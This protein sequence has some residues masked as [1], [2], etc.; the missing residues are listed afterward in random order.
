[1]SRGYYRTALW[2]SGVLDRLAP[3]D[4]HVAGTP[5]LGLDLPDSDIDILCHAPDLD[6]F[7][8]TVRAAFGEERGFVVKRWPDHAAV[9][10]RFVTLDWPIEIFGQ[11]LPVAEQQGWR[12]FE[13][14]RRLLHIGGHPLHDQVMA[15]R[16][17]G[18]KTEPA[19]ATLLK[20]EGDPHAAL[21][22][23]AD[24]PDARLAALLA[25][26]GFVVPRNDGE[27]PRIE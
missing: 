11:A 17:A 9:I 4:P 20:L 18:T 3:F 1:M 15:L 23:L 5:P 24:L 25:A 19:F 2:R 12:H 6:A 14:E 8:A 10:A 21:L 13:V 7:E 26:L 22:A 27:L 16:S